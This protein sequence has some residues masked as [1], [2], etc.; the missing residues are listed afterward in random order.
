[1]TIN[2]IA[3]S[4]DAELL[5]KLETKCVGPTGRCNGRANS[6]SW[7][8]EDTP[9]YAEL[10]KRTSFAPEDT[11]LVVRLTLLRYSHRAW[12]VCETCS[13]K[14]T[15]NAGTR[16]FPRFCRKHLHNDSAVG[17]KKIATS[18][19]R[20][21]EVKNFSSADHLVQARNTMMARFGT[22]TPQKLAS[23]KAKHAATMLDR[24]GVLSP[25]QVPEFKKK[26]LEKRT[27]GVRVGEDNHNY[28]GWRES[29]PEIIAAYEAGEPKQILAERFGYSLSHFNKVI[30]WLGL[31][32]DLPQNKIYHPK[33]T[34][35]GE[36]EVLGYVQELYDGEIIT[37]GRKL[38]GKELDIYVPEYKLAIEFNGDFWHNEEIVGRGKS[39]LKTT[40]CEAH[41]VKLLTIPDHLWRDKRG[42]IEDKI[43][44][45]LGGHRRR[46]GARK[47][48]LGTPSRDTVASF[49]DHYHVQ[50]SARIGSQMRG[51]YFENEMVAVAT[52]GKFREGLELVRYCSKIPITGGLRKL[53]SD[54]EGPIYTFADRRFTYRYHNIYLS[55]G[56]IEISVSPPSYTYHRG[57]TYLSRHQC[58]KHRLG[59]LL[60]DGFDPQMTEYQ[61]M[62]A[63]GW[64]RTFDCGNLLY[65]LR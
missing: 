53:I 32:S 51:L 38:I 22:A 42:H 13:G 52:F 16:S 10:L 1:M 3:A 44:A 17:A 21:G 24:Y 27:V 60:G 12:P 64:V 58:M 28:R 61:N 65:R 54:I 63:N 11:S 56:G 15:F 46:I 26:S 43:V 5:L 47:T 57:K 30:H 8:G 9:L 31:E 36:L 4:S 14:L 34:S 55:N 49:L 6:A 48:V 50:G 41:G 20:Y 39:L 35:K 7:W 33:K 40:L 59:T 29:A 19:A 2:A 23:V 18:M 37:N 25:M 45:A 62:K